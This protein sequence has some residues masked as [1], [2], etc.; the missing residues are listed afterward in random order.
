MIWSVG[1]VWPNPPVGSETFEAH[2]RVALGILE[3]GLKIDR[4]GEH[5]VLAV[6]VRRLAEV[7]EVRLRLRE[8]G[9]RV[10]RQRDWCR[11]CFRHETAVRVVSG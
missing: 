5:R 1:V 4:A 8:D 6:R 2:Y 3:Q 10:R 11:R 9:R 7:D